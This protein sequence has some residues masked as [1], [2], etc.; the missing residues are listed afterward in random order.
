MESC[1]ALATLLHN[2]KELRMST[3]TQNIEEQAVTA[4]IEAKPLEAIVN[5]VRRDSQIDPQAYL[6]ESKV[7]HGGE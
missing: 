3:K 2:S 4:P 6:D 1:L 7:P 5:M